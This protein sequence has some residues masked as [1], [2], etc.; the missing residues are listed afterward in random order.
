M[1]H[2]ESIVK[3]SA[4]DARVVDD[5]LIGFN[6][7]EKLLRFLSRAKKK[8]CTYHTWTRSTFKPQALLC[9]EAGYKP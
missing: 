1:S 6:A 9:L 3:L 2:I 4:D 7:S 5:R 8:G